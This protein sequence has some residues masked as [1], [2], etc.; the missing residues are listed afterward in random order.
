MRTTLDLDEKLMDALMKVTAARTKTEAIHR[1]AAEMI[2]RA[3]LEQLKA[4][5]GKLRLD[6]DWKRLEEIELRHGPRPPR[7]RRGHR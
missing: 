3:R 2:R 5:S 1:A 7:R 4:L 6:L